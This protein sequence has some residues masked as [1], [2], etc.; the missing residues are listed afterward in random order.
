M[1]AW[2]SSRWKT[3]ALSRMF[4]RKFGS[5]RI[6][7]LEL[8]HRRPSYLTLIA[9]SGASVTVTFT[10]ELVIFCGGRPTITVM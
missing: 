4:V 10:T 7:L 1:L 6:T 3:F 2:S 9:T 5:A 8:N